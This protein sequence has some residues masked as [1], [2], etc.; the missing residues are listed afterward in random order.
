MKIALAQLDSAIGD[1]SGN[2]T[3]HLE[4]V[5]MAASHQANLIVFPELSLT[6]YAP[7]LAEETAM[8]IRDP[9][10]QVFSKAS[11]QLKIR[12]KTRWKLFFVNIQTN[13]QTGSI[14][15]RTSKLQVRNFV[16]L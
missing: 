4:M 5:H 16:K 15:T 11:Q 12:L 3:R 14:K 2:R 7:D 8:T 13:F 6:S 10:L 9:K 1:I